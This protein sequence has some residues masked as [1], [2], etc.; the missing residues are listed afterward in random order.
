MKLIP[1]ILCGGAGSRLWPLS[2]SQHPKP[3]I[4]LND[5][6]SL[7]QKAFKRGLQQNDVAEVLTVT[8]RELLFKTEDEYRAIN[9]QEVDTAFILEP[10]GKNTAAAIAAAVL[11]VIESH[12]RDAVL[13]VL[14]ADHLIDNT[15]SFREAVDTATE[16]AAQGKL[17]TFGIKPTA[18][19]TGYGYIHAQGHEVLEFV[20]K[21]DLI[22]AQ[23]YVDSGQFLWNS[24][25][26][27]FKAE[28]M[29]EEMAKL[30]PDILGQVEKCLEQSQKV[31][32]NKVRQ[33]ELN[34]KIFKHVAEAPIDIAVF[35]KSENIAVVP[36][37]IGWSDIGSWVAMGELTTPDDNGN[38]IDGR[39]QLYDTRNCF[40]RSKN[41]LV[42]AVG[43]ENVIIVDTA[44]ALLV[45]HGSKAQ[46]VKH[47]YTELKKIDHESHK[48]HKTVYRP[49]GSFTVLEEGPH[50]KI[51]RIEVKPHSS[52]SLQMHH[53]RSEHWVVLKGE[54]QVVN[55]EQA[56]TIK[57][58]QST[59][60]PAGH[61]HRLCNE[62]D[63][64]LV[65]IEV[66]TGKYVGEDD[67]LRFEDNYGR[68]Q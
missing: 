46:E 32:G 26:F 12:G 23:E 20:E 62:T 4:K 8:N 56:M 40:I 59:F 51:K 16:L 30:C 7:L 63:N 60:I 44:D 11:N 25:M 61:K 67:I 53:H 64:P 31:Q 50:F 17:V 37:D 21:P 29:Y 55:G 6:Q 42:G 66:Q 45:A 43:L 22:T 24:G 58:D 1:T 13:L 65:I 48:L 54:A 14:A 18:P 36:C 10:F 52:L 68:C 2:R 5:G 39:A 15:E 49:W 28:T 19:E 34:A 57:R 27:C 9:Y 41:R 3:F 35:E 38:R 33:I 47:V